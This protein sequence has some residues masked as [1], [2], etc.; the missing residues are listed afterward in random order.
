VSG[1]VISGD[2][3]EQHHPAARRAEDEGRPMRPSRV[4]AYGAV[5]VTTATR[6]G[7]DSV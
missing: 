6:S 2:Q 7:G 1:T 3:P 5:Q 4:V